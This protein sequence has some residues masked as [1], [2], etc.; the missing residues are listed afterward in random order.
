MFFGRDF[1]SVK[2]ETLVLFVQVPS[3]AECSPSSVSET[4]FNQIEG[5]V[6]DTFVTSPTET[7]VDLGNQI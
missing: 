2:S 1:C 4:R 5:A 3:V 6:Q 7:A